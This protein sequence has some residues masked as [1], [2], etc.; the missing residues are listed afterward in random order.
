MKRFLGQIHVSADRCGQS[1]DFLQEFS[2][3]EFAKDMDDRRSDCVARIR[4]ENVSPY[5]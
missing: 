3:F 1:K 5:Y 4:Q 2:G